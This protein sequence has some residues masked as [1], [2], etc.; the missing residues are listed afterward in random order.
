MNSIVLCALAVMW[1]T[2]LSWEGIQSVR[3]GFGRRGDSLTRFRRQLDIM[4]NQPY[5]MGA[6]NRLE[7]EAHGARLC[8]SPR[9]S[10]SSRF[11]AGRRRRDLVFGLGFLSGATIAGFYV[12]GAPLSGWAMVVVSVTFL[13]YGA[14]VVRRRQLAAERAAKVRYLPTTTQGEVFYARGRVN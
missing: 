13:A 5:Q 7:F 6:A 3:E 4:S 12:S 11:E 10:P 14:A 1:V 9:H 8:R 2:V